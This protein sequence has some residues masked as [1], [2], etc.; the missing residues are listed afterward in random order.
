MGLTGAELSLTS[1]FRAA[2]VSQY[3][4]EIQS[5]ARSIRRR[6]LLNLLD[7]Q[8]VTVGVGLFRDYMWRGERRV[9]VR[10]IEMGSVSIAPGVSY[11]LS[12]IGPETRVH[13]RYKA[14]AMTGDAYV[15]WSDQVAQDRTRSVGA[16]GE[17]QL[18]T[19]RRVE[20]RIAFDLWRNPDGTLRVRTEGA[21]TFSGW[22][23]D[24]FVLTTAVGAKGSGYVPGYS[25]TS[26]AYVG[27]G[28]GIRF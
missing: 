16:G 12:P 14:G 17:L 19:I 25:L 11:R 18:G 15:R 28:G 21:A 4:P 24:R 10:W 20:P 7:Y 27:I 22:P 23:T 9:P 8:Y 3:F 5:N 2:E 13:S 6:A 1:P 26:G